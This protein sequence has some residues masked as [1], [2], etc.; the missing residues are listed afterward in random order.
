MEITY[1]NKIIKMTGEEILERE[2]KLSEYYRNHRS[3]WDDLTTDCQ[4]VSS[5]GQGHSHDYDCEECE[6]KYNERSIEEGCD[7]ASH[8]KILGDIS[9]EEH[10]DLLNKLREKI[11]SI[12]LTVEIEC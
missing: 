9:F 2:D 5:H 8:R 6:E 4:S 10:Q 1:G 11:K 7:N 12:N 3:L